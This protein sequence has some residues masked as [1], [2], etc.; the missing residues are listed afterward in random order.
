M[1]LVH[2]AVG[3]DYYVCAVAV[4]SVAGDEKMVKRAAQATCFCSR[5]A[6]PS[7]TLKPGLVYRALSSLRSTDG[8][9]RVVY[10]EA[11]GSCAAASSV[12]GFRR[13]LCRP[14]V[15]VTISSRHRVDRRVCY[16]REKLLEIVE[17]RLMLFRQNGKRDVGS[18]RG[19][20]GSDAVFR[21]RKDRVRL[22]PRMCNQRPCK[23]CRVRPASAFSTL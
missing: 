10:L 12:A 8:E 22:C 7:R 21:H 11:H 1:V 20:I 6:K 9:Y 14:A 18:H 13:S 5:E 17:Q 23:A 2:S 3:E 15:S 19:D 16:L 4:C